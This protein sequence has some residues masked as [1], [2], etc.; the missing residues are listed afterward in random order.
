[1]P[2]PRNVPLVKSLR[3]LSKPD[4]FLS[5]DWPQSIEQHG[6]TQ[7]LLRKKPFFRQ[8]IDSGNLG[9]PPLMGLLQTLRPDWWFS[10]HLHVRFEAIVKHGGSEQGPGEGNPPVVLANPEEI[11]ISDEDVDEDIATE[12]ALMGDVWP[13]PAQNPDEITLVNEEE[14]VEPVPRPVVPRSE[15]KFI[16]LDKCLPRRA[17]LEVFFVVV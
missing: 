9:S 7:G 16:A 17:F 4:I 12:A 13:T 11:V 8:D 1:V 2:S 14:L 6:D 3:Q 5:H 15:T 10:A